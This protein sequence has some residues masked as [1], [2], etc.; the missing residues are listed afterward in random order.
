ML[1][2]EKVSVNGIIRDVSF[3]AKRG[4]FTA[5]LGKN[6]SGKTTLAKCIMAEQKFNGGITLDGIAINDIPS[7]ERAKLVAYLPQS[8]PSPNITVFELVSLGRNPHINLYGKMNEADITAVQN[9]IRDTDMLDFSNRMLPT[10]S[11]GEKQRA[12][13]AMMLTQDADILLLDEP[14]AHMDM[15]AAAEFAELLS[16]LNKTLIVIMHDLTL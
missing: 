10:L 8:L 15:A 14:T 1:K 9:A 11:G 6:G 5:I 12:Y 3:E 16:T 13:L 7:R 4:K 2:C